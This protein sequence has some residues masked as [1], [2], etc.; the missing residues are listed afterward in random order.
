MISVQILNPVTDLIKPTMPP[1]P[2]QKNQAKF[3]QAR[4]PAQRHKEYRQEVCL[5]QQVTTTDHGPNGATE[6][7]Y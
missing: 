7:D 3:I 6:S 5:D 4:K 2:S 1:R